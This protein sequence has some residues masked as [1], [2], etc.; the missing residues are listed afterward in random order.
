MN[1]PSFCLQPFPS[2]SFLPHPRITGSIARLGNTLAIRYVLCGPLEQLVIPWH[3]NKP[4]RRDKLWEET[5]FEF[6][7]AIKYSPRYWEFNLSPSGD[8]NVY[9]LAGYRQ[10]MQEEPALAS[11]PFDVQTQSDVLSL[12]LELDLDGIVQADQPLEV[13]ISA[14][15]KPGKGEATYW[16]L[17]H[18]AQQ[19]DFHRRDSFVIQL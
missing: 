12:A 15:I 4:A 10:G 19:A 17:T 7:L 13:A 3:G 11:L 5:C 14:V 8:W 18:G 1:K 16:A 6:F 9:R 2:A